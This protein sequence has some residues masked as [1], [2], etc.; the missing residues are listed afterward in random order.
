MKL[1]SKFLVLGAVAAVAAIPVFGQEKP[2]SLL[3]PGF[4]NTPPKPAQPAQPSSGTDTPRAQN[5]RRTEQR[6]QAPSA[7]RQRDKVSSSQTQTASPSATTE[8]DEEPQEV[9]IVFDVPPAARRSLSQVG[10]ISG[11]TGGF[12]ID[13]FGNVNGRFAMQVLNRTKGP[14]ASRWGSIMMRRLLSSSIKTP[15]GIDG[16][17]WV[18]ARAWL[19]LRMGE[20]VVSR[21]LVQQVDVADYSAQLYK[22]SMQTFLA[23]ADLGGM[24][25]LADSAASKVQDNDWKMA[26]AICASLAGEQGG[27]TA[28]L[29]QARR[30][31]WMQGIDYQLAEKAIGAGTDGRRSVKIDWAKVKDFNAWRFGTAYATGLEPPKPLIDGSGRHIDGWRAQL[32]M[33][34]MN[35]RIDAAMNAA[36]L[37]VLSNSAL[38]D[39]YSRAMDDQSSNEATKLRADGLRLA[40]TGTDDSAKVTAMAAIWDAT[41]QNKNPLSGLVLTARAAALIAPSSKYG[42][43]ADRLIASMMTAGLD[44]SAA[45]WASEVSSGS[46]GWGILSVGAPGMDG[47]VSYG[48]LDDFYDNDQSEK[49]HKTKLLAAG[50]AGLGRIDEETFKDISEKLD[51]DFM[52]SS[53]WS[54]AISSA[55]D[56][57]EQGTVVLLVAAALQTPDW[58]TVSE[59]H[60]YYITRSLTEVGLEAEARMIA[61]EAVTLG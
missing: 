16:A 26:R 52:R 5:P 39:V 14:L 43:N 49:S 8:E 42:E 27:A 37:G 44:S 31:K 33:I 21:N 57:G 59:R 7:P 28:L 9:R 47:Q 51:V 6:D 35:L 30:G 18:A 45:A 22:V 17:D 55:A 34:D 41:A 20:S 10:L 2:E 46:L 50:L 11:A 56:R 54:E 1:K 36:S 38:I 53:N 58:T 15:R 3:P 19:L 12:P 4:D 13:A 23:T 48:Q 61:A 40:Y 60:L 25:P 29:N 32:P 24:C